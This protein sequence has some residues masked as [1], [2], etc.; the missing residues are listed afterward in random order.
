MNWT[1][2][3]NKGSSTWAQDIYFYFH[4]SIT[5]THESRNN[6]S[7]LTSM[8]NICLTTP[9][10]IVQYGW[11]AVLFLSQVNSTCERIDQLNRGKFLGSVFMSTSENAQPVPT[12][13][14]F[15]STECGVQGKDRDKTSAGVQRQKEKNLNDDNN[16]NNNF[17]KLNK[18]FSSGRQTQN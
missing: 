6:S 3:G 11:F 2:A 15:M 16:D 18:T 8:S 7:I 13:I 17:L 4:V 9:R 1:L 10:K 14:S 12:G 5:F